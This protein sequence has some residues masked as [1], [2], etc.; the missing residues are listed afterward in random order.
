MSFTAKESSN[1]LDREVSRMNLNDQWEIAT[2]P[3]VK[4]LRGEFRVDILS[5]IFVPW[6]WQFKTWTK[7]FG[8]KKEGPF[9]FPCNYNIQDEKACGYFHLLSGEDKYLFDYDLPQ[10]SKA[11]RRLRDEVRKVTDSY[12]I[13]KIYMRFWGR[14]RFMGYF[15]LTRINE[16]P[17]TDTRITNINPLKKLK[18]LETIQMGDCQNIDKLAQEVLDLVA[19]AFENFSVGWDI[20]HAVEIRLDNPLKNLLEG[21]SGLVCHGGGDGRGYINH[22]GDESWAIIHWQDPTWKALLCKEMI[23][24]ATADNPRLTEHD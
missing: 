17:I 19:W 21:G 16:E 15:S 6:A 22:Y 10:N 18:K 4:D 8:A 12:F 23:Q 24:R 11:W 13:G 2:K 14:Y 5:G 3:T 20:C 7:Q 9:K 1:P